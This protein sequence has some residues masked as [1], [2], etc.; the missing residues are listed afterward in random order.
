MASY[1]KKWRRWAWLTIWD[2]VKSRGTVTY[3]CTWREWPVNCMTDISAWRRSNMPFQ[4]R[5]KWHIPMASNG[6][7][8][9]G[10]LNDYITQWRQEVSQFGDRRVWRQD[11][12]EKASTRQKWPQGLRLS[13]TEERERNVVMVIRVGV[14]ILQFCSVPNFLSHTNLSIKVRGIFF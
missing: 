1:G 7:I 4:R 2:K 13:S 14:N 6:K 8:L 11:V 9:N 10:R 12:V 3:W 5:R